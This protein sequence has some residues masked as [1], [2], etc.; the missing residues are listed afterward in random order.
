MYILA[1]IEYHLKNGNTIWAVEVKVF[2]N[3][4]KMHGRGWEKKLRH[5]NLKYYVENKLTSPS[6]CFLFFPFP[7]S[8]IFAF[9]S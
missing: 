6:S 2:Q 3:R 8:S 4:E 9:M 1:I 7:S 5:Q